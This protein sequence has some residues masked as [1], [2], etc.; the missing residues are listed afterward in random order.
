V[1]QRASSFGG[2]IGLSFRLHTLFGPSFLALAQ[3]PMLAWMPLM[4]LPVGID[5]TLKIILIGIA[6][7]IPVVLNVAQGM[8]DVPAGLREAVRSMVDAEPDCSARRGAV[9]LHGAA[10]R[11]RQYLANSDRGQV[12]RVLRKAGLSDV[13]GTPVV[14]T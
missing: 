5:E 12:V 8:R 2:A 1:P 6:T 14:S 7:F 13:L 10:G 11:P 4:I 9:D 3:V